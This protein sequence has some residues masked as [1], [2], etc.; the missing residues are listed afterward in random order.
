MAL[1]LVC[2][3]VPTA[4]DLGAFHLPLRSVYADCLAKGHAFDWIPNLYSGFYLSGEGQIGAYHPLHLFL[5]GILPLNI[6][7]NV[8]ILLNYPFMWIGTFLFLRRMLQQA[9]AASFGAMAFTFSGFN[10]LHFVH[11]NAIAIVAHLPWMLLAF[12]T[13]WCSPKKWKRLVAEI[14]V[15]AILASQILLGYPQYVWFCG[16]ASCLFVAFL[17]WRDGPKPRTYL[18]LLAIFVLGFAMGGIQLLSTFDVLIRSSRQSNE[19]GFLHTGALHPL[20]LLQ[21]VAPY[22]FKG[23][24]VGGNTHEYGIYLSATSLILLCWVYNRLNKGI[25]HRQLALAVAMFGIVSLVLAMGKYGLLY[26]VQTYLPVV[27]RFRF[28]ARYI[29]LVHFASAVL[30]AIAISDLKSCLADGKGNRKFRR[31]GVLPIVLSLAIAVAAIFLR[32]DFLGPPILIAAGPLLLILATLNLHLALR[33]SRLAMVALVV[34]AAIDFG[35]YGLSYAALRQCVAVEEFIDDTD[36]PPEKNGY[37]IVVDRQIREANDTIRSGNRW[38]LAGCYQADGYA[39]LEPSSDL[40]SS[41]ISLRSLQ[42]ANVRWVRN[43]GR[44]GEIPGLI[45]RDETWLEVP[46][47]CAR[48]RLVTQCVVSQNAAQA[49]LDSARDTAI[50]SQNIKL[51]GGPAGSARISQDVP[52]KIKILAKAP[53]VQLLVVSERYHDG[54]ICNVRGESRPVL[55]VNGDFMGCL[56]QPGTQTVSFVFQ[57][58]SLQMG[59]LI[60]GVGLAAFVLFAVWRFRRVVSSKN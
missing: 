28:P 1:P 57:P 39:G 46:E 40:R 7:F 54:W 56:V 42:V 3:Q 29:V 13:L 17:S 20:N 48:A 6:A 37:R 45:P 11:P 31:V 5:Y 60:S 10:L 2:G 14:S 51:S 44:N 23:R 52:G 35:S 16:F 43:C 38:V 22:T 26:Y 8:E 18:L 21:F 27:G 19:A 47:P 9:D 32:K 55:R 24:V 50:V 58:R 34:L 33:G 41:N 4:D 12:D 59:K 30:S 53:S 49:L 36:L 15:P 25:R